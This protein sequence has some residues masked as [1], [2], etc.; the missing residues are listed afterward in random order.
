MPNRWRA[1]KLAI[2]EGEELAGEIM[3]LAGAIA[4]VTGRARS[5]VHI[6]YAPSAGGRLGFGGHLVE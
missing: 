2:P 5:C 3:A 4:Q 6:E 1:L